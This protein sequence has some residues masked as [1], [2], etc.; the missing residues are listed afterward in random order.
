MGGEFTFYDY[1]SADGDGVNVIKSWL[2][3]DG[4]PAKAFFTN[5]IV[6][7][8]ASPPPRVKDSVWKEPYTKHMDG[9]WA[10]FIELRKGGSVQYR[11]IAKM[12]DRSVFLLACGVHKGQNFITDVSPQTASS[13]A[14]QMIN[15]PEKYR[16][17]HEYN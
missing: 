2:N 10:G 8:E 12:Q 17:E 4:K 14:T 5:M 1:I 13:R 16:R 3:G 7:L 15:N 11:L 6:Q 9:K